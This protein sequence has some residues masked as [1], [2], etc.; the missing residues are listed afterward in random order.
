V[1]FRLFTVVVLFHAGRLLLLQRAPWK[2]F[3]PNRWTG[4]GGRVEMAEMDDLAAAARR[5]LFEE[6]DIRP[7]EISELRLRRTLTMDRPTEGLLCL[8]Y[9]TGETSSDRVPTCNEGSLQWI[10]PEDLAR[11]DLIENSAPIVPR[12]VEDVRHD[13]PGILC[14]VA[15][16]GTDG[17]LTRVFFEGEE[18]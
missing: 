15:S 6:T 4:I 14:G 1:S 16:Y 7:D 10:A 8:L 11:L 13:R 12:L 18:S 2:A 3:A 9:F 5:E 17:Q